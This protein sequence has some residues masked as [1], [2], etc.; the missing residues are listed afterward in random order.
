MTDYFYS[1]LT[2]YLSCFY[3]YFFQI[4]YELKS[5]ICEGCWW[6]RWIHFFGNLCF[7]LSNLTIDQ[8]AVHLP[9]WPFLNFGLMAVLSSCS[10][11]KKKSEKI[12]GFLVLSS[13]LSFH[14]WREADWM[15]DLYTFC[16]CNRMTLKYLQL[17]GRIQLP[18]ALAL[19]SLGTSAS[20]INVYLRESTWARNMWITHTHTHT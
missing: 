12:L 20:S 5:T 16:L 17:L 18:A 11:L 2:I 7:M 13:R 6:I 15:G 10:S 9:K 14:C 8:C 19:F 3:F 4:S 1:F